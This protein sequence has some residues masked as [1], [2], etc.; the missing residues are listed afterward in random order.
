M[1]RWRARVD[2]RGGEQRETSLPSYATG[3]QGKRRCSAV[4][5]KGRVAGRRPCRRSCLG[6]SPPKPPLLTFGTTVAA[7]PQLPPLP[8]PRLEAPS[9]PKENREGRKHLGLLGWE[10]AIAKLRYC[11]RPTLLKRA[12]KLHS[13]RGSPLLA[14]V[15]GEKE[16]MMAGVHYFLR[17]RHPCIVAE[18]RGG[19]KDE[20]NYKKNPG[21]YH[22]PKSNPNDADEESSKTQ[23]ND[24]RRKALAVEEKIGEKNEE[25]CT[26]SSSSESDSSEDEKG[27]L[28]LF[29]QED[30]DEEMCFMAEEEEKDKISRT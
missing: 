13:R 2:E 12:R 15:S 24:K 11:R 30:S 5:E 16:R 18:Q 10:V 6:A 28:C 17:R 1:L 8:Q 29:S 25:S 23:K 9:S 14:A 3:K 19:R 22:H 26:S 7:H 20:H 27:L 4:N 21:R